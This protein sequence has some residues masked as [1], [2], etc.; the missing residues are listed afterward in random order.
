MTQLETGPPVAG[1]REPEGKLRRSNQDRVVAGICG[2]LGQYFGVDPVWFRLAFVV[3]AL[4]GGAG[5]VIYVVGW[6]IIPEAGSE[7]DLGARAGAL[8]KDGPVVAGV[9][10]VGVGVLLLFNNLIPWFDQVIW[11]L[12]VIVTGIGLLYTGSRHDHR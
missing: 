2:G 4:G 11:P 9:A 3:L 8:A 6:L 7:E 5:V 12:A 10:L 1:N